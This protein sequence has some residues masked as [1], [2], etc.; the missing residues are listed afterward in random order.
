MSS[1]KQ[2]ARFLDA[3][4]NLLEILKTHLIAL[5]VSLINNLNWI[6][7]TFLCAYYEVKSLA[8]VLCYSKKPYPRFGTD[9]FEIL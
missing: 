7:T 5:T 8:Q 1:T 6:R 2:W 9:Y 3:A 4:Y